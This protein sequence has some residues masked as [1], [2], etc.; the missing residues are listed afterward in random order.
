MALSHPALRWEPEADTIEVNAT[1][2]AAM[3]TVAM[4]HFASRGGSHLVGISSIAAIR[5]HGDAPWYGASKAFVSSYLRAL[6]HKC[7]KQRLRMSVTESQPGFVATAMAKG[8]GLF[9]GC[10]SRCRGP[11]DRD[12]NRVAKSSRVCDE[13]VATHCGHDA[14][15]ARVDLQS[16]VTVSADQAMQ[17][18]RDRIGLDG[19]SKVAS[20]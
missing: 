7:A 8:D 10:P 2:F 3:A 13:T 11:S 16:N 17:R 20:R 9:W 5:G 14:A 15:I 4:E 18:T 19:K 6:R 1:G 12:G